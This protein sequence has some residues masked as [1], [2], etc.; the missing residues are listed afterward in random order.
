METILGQDV[1]LRYS[2]ENE[3]DDRGIVRNEIIQFGGF[4]IGIVLRN[5]PESNIPPADAIAIDLRRTD[6]EVIIVFSLADGMT[7]Y[8]NNYDIGIDSPRIA[9]VVSSNAT[10]QLMKFVNDNNTNYREAIAKSIIK[11]NSKLKDEDKLKGGTTLTSAVFRYNLN[12]KMSETKIY[13][14]GPGKQLGILGLR[15]QSE[16][17]FAFHTFNTDP[18]SNFLY[19][20]YDFDQALINS[21]RS[22][23]SGVILSTDGI[24]FGRNQ[25]DV[26]CTQRFS[27]QGNIFQSLSDQLP[28]PILTYPGS[29]D[30]LAIVSIVPHL[31]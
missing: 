29:R 30:D 26:F 12:S 25:R 5:K 9:T 23:S 4:D 19:P 14:V 22:N 1:S 20:Y 15:D 2:S 13:T 8:T 3:S 6:E 16:N 24:I 31:E 28:Q 7:Y 17:T 21:Y 11:S 18:G 10:E 27:Y